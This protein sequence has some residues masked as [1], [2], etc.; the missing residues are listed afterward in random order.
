MRRNVKLPHIG[1]R[2]LKTTAAI[3]LSM[4]LVYFYGTTDSKYIFAMLG[5]MA[6]MEPSFKDSLQAC[7]TQF[8]GVLCGAIAGVL[9][10]WL[11]IHS[12][13][14]C[15]MGILL[16]ITLY[17]TLR[18]RFSPSLPCMI[19]VIICTTPDVQPIAMAAG[20]FWDTAIGLTVGMLINTIVFP[21][22]NSQRIHST[23]ESLD[24]EV[25]RFLEE[26]FDGDHVMPNSNAM[27]Q[28]IDELEQQ[29]RIFSGQKLF[30]RRRKQSNQLTHFRMGEANARSLLAQMEVLCHMK[31]PGRL[32]EENRQKLAEA[33]ANIRDMQKS[34]DPTDLDMITN[35]HVNQILTLRSHLLD[36]LKH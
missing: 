17:N 12:L 14:R 4:M 6:A 7:M 30:L 33:G 28:K 16:I 29:L 18:I 1:L 22:D 21:Y 10:L 3:I 23:M 11:P 8:V 32:T 36:T 35:Y 2:T 34:G 26:M 9:L 27:V 20:R 19:V 31:S 25:I 5:A 15:A 13:L 24:R